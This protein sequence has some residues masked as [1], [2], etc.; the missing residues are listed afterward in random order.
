[1]ETNITIK[2]KSKNKRYK[3]SKFKTRRY[4]KSK[5]K[6]KKKLNKI[7]RGGELLPV[8]NECMYVY[9]DGPGPPRE[10]NKTECHDKNGCSWGHKFLASHPIRSGGMRCYKTQNS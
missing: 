10:R 2:R 6:S 7:K 1:M 3:K 4:K 9:P 5:K 8:G